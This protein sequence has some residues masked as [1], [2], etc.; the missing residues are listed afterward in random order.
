MFGVLL[1]GIL[2][3]APAE[4]TPSSPEA[5]TQSNQP[6]V[7][8]V[9]WQSLI[10]SDVVLERHGGEAA[11]TGQLRA[12]G[13]STVVVVLEDGQ[14]LELEKASVA[15]VRLAQVS[16]AEEPPASEPQPTVTAAPA[17]PPKSPPRAAGPS[18]DPTWKKQYGRA[19]ASWIAGA[20]MAGVSVG[21]AGTG[22][23][24]I[25]TANFQYTSIEDESGDPDTPPTPQEQELLDDADRT[26][27]IGQAML[28]SGA[29]L[30]GTGVV[31]L[32]IGL[33]KRKQLRREAGLVL[34]PAGP[35][36]VLSGRF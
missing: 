8:D 29:V 24:L 30:A 15:N 32:A 21:I 20:A 7:G 4:G 1:V 25:Y 23:Y 2:A 13:E 27:T 11:L 16:Q 10:G 35:G 36:L 17:P 18:Q 9:A 14:V 5:T 3:I 6:A 12:V 28:I 33:I 22:G 26:R 31:L 19:N 34:A